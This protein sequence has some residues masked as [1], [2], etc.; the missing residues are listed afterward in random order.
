MNENMRKTND[1]DTQKKDYLY[2]TT[3]T[4]TQK[5]KQLSL[6]KEEEQKI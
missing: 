4:T 5:R 6:C 2:P 3:D 1:K